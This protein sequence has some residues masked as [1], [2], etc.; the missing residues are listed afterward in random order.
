MDHMFTN[1]VNVRLGKRRAMVHQLDLSP[2][3]TVG[4]SVMRE[5]KACKERGGVGPLLTMW[6]E[7][8]RVGLGVEKMVNRASE[9]KEAGTK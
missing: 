4:V 8:Q 5:S 9:V 1:V 7:V 6:F 3:A 2:V